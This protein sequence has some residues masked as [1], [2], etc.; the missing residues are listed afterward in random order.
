[1]SHDLWQHETREAREASSRKTNSPRCFLLFPKRA[2]HSLSLSLSLSFSLA[3]SRFPLIRAALRAFQQ[4]EGIGALS[5]TRHLEP[6]KLRSYQPRRFINFYTFVHPLPPATASSSRGSLEF[7]YD[8]R[9]PLAANCAPLP[10][11][12]FG[13]DN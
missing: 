2:S 7:I 4:L 10:F 1:M 6:T 8:P 12:A 5:I 11:R 3:R 9:P 13:G